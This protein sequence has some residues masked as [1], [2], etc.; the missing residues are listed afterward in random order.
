MQIRAGRANENVLVKRLAE[1]YAKSTANYVGLR[2]HD[3]PFTFK[4][5]EKYLYCKLHYLFLMRFLCDSYSSNMCA[6]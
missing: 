2:R 4:D 5:F 6:A 3:G 1:D